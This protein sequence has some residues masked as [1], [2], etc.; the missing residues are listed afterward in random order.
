MNRFQTLLSI[1]TCAATEGVTVGAEGRVVKIDLSSYCHTASRT[2]LTSLPAELGGLTALS[3]LNLDQC[4]LKSLPGELGVGRCTR[5]TVLKS[6][7]KARLV[8][9]FETKTC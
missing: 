2:P 9:A 8:S 6:E 1:L 3:V 4:S 5:L 7:L